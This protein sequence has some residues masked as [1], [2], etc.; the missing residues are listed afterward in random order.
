MTLYF[1]ILRKCHIDSIKSLKSQ[2]HVSAVY[3]RRK[4]IPSSIIFFLEH[5]HD[6]I[7]NDDAGNQFSVNSFQFYA[8]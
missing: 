1:T 3:I 2:G 7:L 6:N 8:N 5:M 4:N